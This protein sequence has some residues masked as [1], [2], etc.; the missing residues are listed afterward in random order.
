VGERPRSLALRQCRPQPIPFFDVQRKR[1]IARAIDCPSEVLPTPGGPTALRYLVARQLEAN[2]LKEGQVEISEAALS[3]IVQH[4]TRE[5][6]VRG[7][8]REIG[9]VLR[10]AAV[11][12]A[13]GATGSIRIVMRTKRSACGGSSC[14]SAASRKRW[15]RRR[16]RGSSA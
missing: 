12:I 15:S 11:R 3:E 6:G 7:L 10:H 1:F 13:E 8:E 14:R 2:G 16:G 4:Y 5:A 9:K